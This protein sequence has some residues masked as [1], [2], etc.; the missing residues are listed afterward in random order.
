MPSYQ[1]KTKRSTSLRLSDQARQELQELAEAMRISQTAVL[2]T[3]IRKLH[4]QE[5]KTMQPNLQQLAQKFGTVTHEGTEYTLTSVADFSSR[6]FD[7]NGL[8]AQEGEPYTVEFVC[9]A[10]DSEG[11]EYEIYWQFDGIIKGEE[12]AP[13]MYDWAHGDDHI[14]RIVPQ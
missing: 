6:L 14:T 3:A 8:N 1:Q 5:T 11:N 2:E 7:G 13:D 12:P 10:I 9:P 4:Q